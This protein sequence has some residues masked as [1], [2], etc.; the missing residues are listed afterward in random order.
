MIT[1]PNAKINIGLDIIRRRPDGYHDLVTAMVPTDW[2]DVLEIVPASAPASTL[3]VTGRSVDCPPESNLVM[4]A[5]RLMQRTYGLDR[6]GEMDIYLHKVIPDGA[7]LGGGSADAAFTLRMVNDIA[8]LGASQSELARLAA[9]LGADCAFFV[10]N[11]PMLCTG[12][13]DRL[14]PL[15]LSLNGLTLAIIKPDSISVNTRQ[16]YSGVTP[17]VPDVPLP[18]LLALPVSE[19]QGRV[20]NAFEASVF[21]QFPALSAIKTRLLSLGALYASMSGSGSAI[22]ALF[23]SSAHHA[24]KLSVTISAAF[25][26]CHIHVSPTWQ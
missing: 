11:T 13:G 21:P 15:P 4:K 2:R 7:G 3:T 19:W 5:L 22:Y 12:I 17:A 16:A 26:S 6:V 10:Y 24:D 9:S 1:F 20:V 8:G 23:D 18:D 25:P 14:S